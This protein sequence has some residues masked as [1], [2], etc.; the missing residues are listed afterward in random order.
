MEFRSMK[1]IAGKSIWWN[2]EH[3]VYAGQQLA[4]RKLQLQS[5][6]LTKVKV[7]EDKVVRF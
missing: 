4:G 1:P 6:T 7:E 5:R 2:G 3:I